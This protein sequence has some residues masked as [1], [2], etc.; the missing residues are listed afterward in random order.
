MF[1]LKQ[2]FIFNFGELDFRRLAR[3]FYFILY[4]GF[5]IFTEYSDVIF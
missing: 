4:F 2:N 1:W 3:L 5:L